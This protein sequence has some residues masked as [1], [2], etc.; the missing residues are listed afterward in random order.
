[1]QYNNYF[2]NLT[3]LLDDRPSKS[4]NTSQSPTSCPFT[5]VILYIMKSLSISS[6]QLFFDLFLPIFPSTFISITIL[7]T[8]KSSTIHAQT[9]S[10]YSTLAHVYSFRILFSLVTLRIYLSILISD[11]HPLFSFFFF[12]HS[13]LYNITCL[14]PTF[15]NTYILILSA[16]S[17]HTKHPNFPP[18]HLSSIYYFFRHANKFNI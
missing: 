5:P 12:Q 11:T 14:A 13:V 8:F 9:I 1:M 2:V 7:S 16:S 3:T 17:C 6:I 4:Y 18:L 15:Y 10:T